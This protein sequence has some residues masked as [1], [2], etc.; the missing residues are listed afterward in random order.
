[1]YFR[2]YQRTQVI[3][4]SKNYRSVDSRRER[5]PTWL[6]A[7]KPEMPAGFKL[8]RWQNEATV[9][10]TWRRHTSARTLSPSVRLSLRLSICPCTRDVRIP[11]LLLARYVPNV[12]KRVWDQYILRSKDR[13]TTDLTF[14]KISNSNFAARGHLIHFMFGS[15]VGF[16]RSADRMALFPVWTN[17]IGVWEKTIREE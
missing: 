7:A 12:E 13:P 4:P 5:A 3:R 16:S 11:F 2:C 1:M 17:S 10:F 14:A 9:M 15:T 6:T 8:Q